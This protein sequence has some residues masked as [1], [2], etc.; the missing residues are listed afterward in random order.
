MKKSLLF[1]GI[2]MASIVGVNAQSVFFGD[3]FESYDV[4]T[5]LAEKGYILWEGGATVEAEAGTTNKIANL[6]P[7]AQNFYF[8][9]EFKL[10]E[11][12]SYTFEVS[13]K[14]PDAKNHRVVAKVGERTIQS[15]LINST[16]W[17]N[18]TVKFTVGTGETN[19]ILWIYSFP[20]SVV[21]LDNYKLIDDKGVATKINSAPDLSVQMFPNPTNGELNIYNSS[22]ILSLNVYDITGKM[23]ETRN[24][25]HR[26]QY[27]MD[28]SSYQK[29]VYFVAVKDVDGNKSTRKIMVH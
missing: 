6:N 22:R 27:R 11:G 3:D 13:T 25:V 1:L 17:K 21:H 20:V 15:D 19:V 28:L 2:L 8:R 16:T 10:E 12:K 4:G 26:E 5:N 9:R 23:I 18:T 24:D 7:S 14:S 29:G